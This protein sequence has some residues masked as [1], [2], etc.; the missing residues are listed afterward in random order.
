MNYSTLQEA[1]NIDS[2][3]KSNK[4]IKRTQIQNDSTHSKRS[5][6][7][8]IQRRGP[9]HTESGVKTSQQEKIPDY[10]QYMKNMGGTCAPIQAPTYTIPVSGECRKELDKVMKVY[11]EEN[12]NA[13]NNVDVTNR[14]NDNVM[15]YYD[16]DLEQYF[17][18]NNLVDEVKYNSK[19][20]ANAYMPNSNKNPYTNDNTGEY[21]NNINLSSNGNNLLNTSEYNL[22]PEEKKKASDA[23]LYLKE[24]EAKI[25]KDENNAILDQIKASNNTGPGGF[26]NKKEVKETNDIKEVKDIKEDKD[27]K[28]VKKDEDVKVVKEDK[29]TKSNYMNMFINFFIFLLFGIVII[30]LC[31]YIVE[32]AI[33]IG[34][35]RTV[36][37]LEPY[38]RN[39]IPLQNNL[40]NQP[41][42]QTAI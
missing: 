28:E 2:F 25:N 36:N 31:D 12:F 33:Q 7:E 39:Q 29:E 3:G 15:P 37:I 5:D 4:Q 13:G 1:Y 8:T 20:I 26:S 27:V 38:I 35:K 23:L 14:S 6:V 41:I 18:I 17:N 30:I 42:L 10:N 11:T 19:S 32:I 34:M 21:S 22:S 40:Y 16:E 9:N 24:L